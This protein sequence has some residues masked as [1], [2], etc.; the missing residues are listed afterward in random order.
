[1]FG[2]KHPHQAEAAID[3]YREVFGNNEL[4]TVAR[5]AEQTGPAKEG[6]LV[7]ADFMSEC[8]GRYRRRSCTTCWPAA[9]ANKSTGSLELSCP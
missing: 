2:D 8:P 4:G 7:F 9:P 1:M 3:F 5:Y 6:A